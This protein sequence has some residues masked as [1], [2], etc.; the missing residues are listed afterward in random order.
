MLTLVDPWAM[1][2]L[3]VLT[4]CAVKNLYNCSWL[5]ISVAT[6]AVSAIRGSWSASVFTERNP[7]ISGPVQFRLCCSRVSYIVNFPIHK[8]SVFLYLHRSSLI[9]F[10]EDGLYFHKCVLDHPHSLLSICLYLGAPFYYLYF[11]SLF[12]SFI[13]HFLPPFGLFEYLCISFK[14][15][16]SWSW[17]KTLNLSPLIMMLAMV[18][19]KF[20]RPKVSFYS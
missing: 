16:C 20:F 14:C 7:C 11:L 15:I 18:F 6:S 10:I 8:H 5:S 3:E 4:L 17:G 9:Y 13:A 19:H 12:H 2:E 1:W